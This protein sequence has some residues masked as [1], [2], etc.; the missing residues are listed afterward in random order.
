M[1]FWF[2][3]N[4]EL[5]DPSTR[6]NSLPAFK[7][8][9]TNEHTTAIFA[10][11][12]E[13]QT[14]ARLI[15]SPPGKKIPKVPIALLNAANFP[16][17]PR[18]QAPAGVR[19]GSDRKEE[20]KGPSQQPGHNTPRSTAYSKRASNKSNNRFKRNRGP[21]TNF[22]PFF[23][24]SPPS[25]LVP[26]LFCLLCVCNAWNEKSARGATRKRK[27]FAAIGSRT[28]ARAAGTSN[29]KAVESAVRK[30]L[31]QCGKL[32]LCVCVVSSATPSS[33]TRFY[34][35]L[36]FSVANFYAFHNKVKIS[37]SI[38]RK[39]FSISRGTKISLL[40]YRDS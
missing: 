30:V 32:M 33:P 35:S 38:W 27:T 11:F 34:G 9:T 12:F 24:C 14:R 22:F 21:G 31:L 10:V 3:K 20:R 2:M 15:Q 7:A 28:T 36:S 40:A 1:F 23:P 26:T 4:M 13:K 16:I 18:H 17:P 8:D 19:L 6:R 37:A 39:I 5:K 29:R 25:S